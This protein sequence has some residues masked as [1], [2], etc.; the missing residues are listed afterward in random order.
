MT[1]HSILLVEDEEPVAKGVRYALESEGWRVDWAPDAGTALQR[2]AARAPDV[3]ILDVRLPDMSGFEL[4]R[5]LRRAH[6]FPVLFL[7][8]RDEEM[9]RVL[10]LEL[11]A[12]DYMTKPFA[13][14]ELVARVRALLRRAY[15][16]YAPTALPAVIIRR[17]VT[18]DIERRRVSK[19]GRPIDLTATEFQILHELARS[20]GRVFSREALLRA[21][22]DDGG[23]LGDETTVTVHIRHLREKIEDQPDAPRHILTVRGVGYTFA[24][25]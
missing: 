23:W 12:D 13:V 4:C 3:A 6:T 22:R 14:R 24:E 8:A 11:G 25:G 19:A 20:P 9:D 1:Q 10:G 15:G 18:I 5:E 7:T 2:L 21:A 16:A 17:D